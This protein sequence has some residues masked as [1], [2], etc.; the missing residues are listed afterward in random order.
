VNKKQI[1]FEF[2]ILG[3]D[4]QAIA[5]TH[6]ISRSI[7]DYTIKEQDWTRLP[8][9]NKLST[10][11]HDKNPSE[12]LMAQVA[13][14]ATLCNILQASELTPALI[15]LKRA[16]IASC[17]QMLIRCDEPA[18]LKTIAEITKLIEPQ[19]TNNGATDEGLKIMVVNQFGDESKRSLSNTEGHTEVILEV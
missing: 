1:Q 4:V 7:L 3:K 18:A 12:D 5:K 15:G 13:E 17:E 11:M 19:T 6:N 10:W 16:I 9:A 2:E 8:I 14:Q